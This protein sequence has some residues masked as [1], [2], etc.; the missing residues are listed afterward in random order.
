MNNIRHEGVDLN[1]LKLAWMGFKKKMKGMSAKEK[2]ACRDLDM[3]FNNLVRGVK[4]FYQTTDHRERIIK[5][6]VCPSLSKMI[7]IGISLAA[8]GIASGGI[9][10]PA[11]AA[12]TGLALSKNA[13]DKERKLI[14]DEIDIELQVVD[15]EIKRVE[16]NGKSSKKYRALLTYQKN[17]Q[18]EKQRI[19]YNLSRKGKAIPVKSTAGLGGGND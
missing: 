19:V 7:K 12:V 18:R 10:L 3:A 15:R 14:L 11:I 2:E 16:D 9:T 13:S 4:S 6:Q 1:S 5:G 8:L 17:L